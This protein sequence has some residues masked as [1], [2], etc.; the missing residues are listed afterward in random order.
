MIVLCCRTVYVTGEE[1]L[2]R[3]PSVLRVTTSQQNTSDA[4]EQPLSCLA[5]YVLKTSLD[6]EARATCGRVALTFPFHRA[7]GEN[8]AYG[9]L[10]TLSRP[11]SHTLIDAQGMPSTL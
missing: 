11:S 6:I 7:G 9:V 3:T 5:F 4:A 1:T 2:S 10:M 8:F